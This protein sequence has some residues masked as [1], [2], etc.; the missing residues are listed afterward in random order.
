M[1]IVFRNP[2]GNEVYVDENDATLVARN[3]E[4]D[5]FSAID[6]STN[7]MMMT[8]VP[9]ATQIDPDSLEAD[10][11]SQII[12]SQGNDM[13]DIE[14]NP[15]KILDWRNLR[16]QSAISGQA[17][18]TKTPIVFGRKVFL[19]RLSAKQSIRDYPDMMMLATAEDWYNYVNKM[20][21]NPI[22]MGAELSAT[23]SPSQRIAVT[24]FVAEW[25]RD[26]GQQTLMRKALPGSD[27]NEIQA[28]GRI[29]YDL[30]TGRVPSPMKA[31]G[32]GTLQ[33]DKM[34][35]LA[36]DIIQTLP[37]RFYNSYTL[38]Q[39]AADE[40]EQAFREAVDRY[41][42]LDL[43]EVGLAIE[44][45]LKLAEYGPG[46]AQIAVSDPTL[47][48]EAYRLMQSV[49][50][51][52]NVGDTTVVR[53]ALSAL[54]D[55]PFYYKSVATDSENI[56]KAKDSIESG[57]I[58]GVSGIPPKV[59]G[60]DGDKDSY[61]YNGMLFLKDFPKEAVNQQGII[62]KG[63]AFNSSVKGKGFELVKSPFDTTVVG[64]LTWGDAKDK[65][66]W[67][68]GFKKDKFTTRN[69]D[70]ANF[71][72]MAEA[73]G[74]PRGKPVGRGAFYKVDIHPKT[75]LNLKLRPTSSS[76]QGD[77]RHG[78]PPKSQNTVTKGLYNILRKDI[79]ELNAKHLKKGLTKKQKFAEMSLMVSG[80]KHKKTG[81]WAPYRIKLP[82]S[83]FRI[84]RQ[85]GEEIL[86]LRKN[87]RQNKE[88]VKAWDAFTAEYGLMK[89]SDNKGTQF[90]F[91]PVDKRAN[92]YQKLRKQIGNKR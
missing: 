15:P 1:S 30:M 85:D 27:P 69:D 82:K 43:A 17:A 75:Q 35:R 68:K 66:Q 44:L 37:I 49:V 83:H 79:E 92:Y 29:A 62:D 23:V 59:F 74:N 90:R 28:K 58:V 91:I 16:L 51:G 7:T 60:D 47:S 54:L 39:L 6:P 20:Q 19:T 45:R 71:V 72:E 53:S 24:K 9:R 70:R 13:E 78:I 61:Y 57:S 64:V 34:F 25:E 80:G 48:N 65:I 73:L 18:I 38:F 50:N 52:Y 89:R 8:S 36:Y 33:Y 21:K 12:D 76:G 84:G 14:P 10:Y 26:P 67:G 46:Y 40:G 3:D 63:N 31:K 32:Y 11:E 87:R 41:V 55:S 56:I 5:V 88:L 42:P 77:D 2:H 81:E 4:E 86:M 22:D